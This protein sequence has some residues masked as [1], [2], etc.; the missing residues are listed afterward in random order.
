[1]DDTI[2]VADLLYSYNENRMDCY[3]VKRAYEK[4]LENAKKVNI[5]TIIAL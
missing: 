1:M 5:P 2:R 3:E 4:N